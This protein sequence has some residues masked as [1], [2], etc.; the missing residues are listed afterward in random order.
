MIYGPHLR[1]KWKKRKYAV[2]KILQLKKIRSIAIFLKLTCFEFLTSRDILLDF[3]T[4]NN[5]N[6]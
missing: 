4:N 2:N 3:A 5:N 1:L 6:I